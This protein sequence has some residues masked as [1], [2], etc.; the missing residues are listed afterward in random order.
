[1]ATLLF[2]KKFHEAI[3]SGKKT[4]TIRLWDKCWVKEGRQYRV[5]NLGVVRVTR[6]DRVRVS[7]LTE[8]DAKLDGFVTRDELFEEIRKIY[9]LKSL[10]AKKCYR[11]RFT[12]LGR[13]EN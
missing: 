1:M 6:I 5:H 13:N 8:R 9:K 3:K 11:I 12:F 7:E 2:K 4:Q 10:G